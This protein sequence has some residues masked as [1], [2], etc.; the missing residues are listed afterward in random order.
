MDDSRKRILNMLSEGKISIDEAEQLLAALSGGEAPKAETA[1]L[2]EQV[3]KGAQGRKPSK[4]RVEVRAGGM[5][6]L[7]NANVNVSVPLKLA[8]TL[9]PIIRNNIPPSAQNELDKQN[10]D[11]AMIL[12]SLDELIDSIEVG[13]DIVNVDAGGI[14]NEEGSAKV[15]IY[16]E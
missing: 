15:R 16:F 13:E 9:F 14:D 6:G 3:V 11:L 8:K 5:D 10:I 12:D 7:K 4:L 1:P 2:R